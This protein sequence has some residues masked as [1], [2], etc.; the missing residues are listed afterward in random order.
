MDR[1]LKRKKKAKITSEY[2]G[3]DRISILTDDVI[4]QILKF[5]DTKLAVQTSVLSKRW[6][7]VWTTLP[8]LKFNWDEQGPSKNTTN[9]ACHVLNHRNHQSQVSNLELAYLPPGLNDKFIEYAISHH[10]Q[11]LNVQFRKKHKPYKLSNFSSNSIQ[12][13]E[14]RM[15]L[16]DLVSESDCWDLPSLKTLHLSHLYTGSVYQILPVRCLTSLPSL[17]TLHL[18]LWNFRESSLHLSMPDLT[19]LH[20]SWCQ[21]PKKFGISLL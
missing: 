14:L 4:H 10:V 15:K 2:K 21:M 12:N 9:F 6:K 11:H 5:V 17:R 16:E 3:E 19:T 13:F 18:S 7:L 8:F 1:P 20:L